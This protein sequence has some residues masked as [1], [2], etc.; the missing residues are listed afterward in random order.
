MTH[1]HDIGKGLTILRREQR[2]H[3]ERVADLDRFHAPSE[4][5]RDVERGEARRA[6]IVRRIVKA[7]TGLRFRVFLR[8]VERRTSPRWVH[9]HGAYH[10]GA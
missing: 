2:A 5:Y 4:C 8:E 7:T 3:V 1:G 10:E 6:R 9:E